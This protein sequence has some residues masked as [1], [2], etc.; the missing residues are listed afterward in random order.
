MPGIK[1]LLARENWRVSIVRTH[2]CDKLPS[3]KTK[4]EAASLWLS[5]GLWKLAASWRLGNCAVR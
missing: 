1:P 3:P 5:P 4:S 2:G